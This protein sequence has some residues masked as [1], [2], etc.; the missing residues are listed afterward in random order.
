MELIN[1]DVL[2]IDKEELSLKSKIKIKCFANK[3]EVYQNFAEC[4]A[5][6]IKR[7]NAERKTTK[8]IL[9]VGPKGQYPILIDKCNKE[10]ISWKKV[11]VFMMDEYLDWQGRLIP[12]DHPLSFRGY[13]RKMFA[14]L[15]FDLKLPEDHF[16]FPDP[17]RLDYYSEEMKG[18][19]GIDTCYGGIGSHGHVAFNEPPNSRLLKV[20]LEQ[21]KNSLTRIVPLAPETVVMNSVRANG[22]NYCEFPPM[23][24]TVGMKDILSAKRI[25]LYCDGGEWQ[26][27]ALR[28]ALL[29]NLTIDYPVT[30]LQEHKDVMIVADQ[31]TAESPKYQGERL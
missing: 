30:L 13:I 10:K 12:E 4:I 17:R 9:P 5:E 31:V 21:F 18:L 6:E 22:G 27:F 25:R 1:Q 26:R 7:N 11:Y 29:G 28:M 14:Q 20:S 2:L 3:Q 24:V 16:Y 23:A 8:L 19:G 15:D